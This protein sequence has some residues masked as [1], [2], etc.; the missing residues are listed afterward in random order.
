MASP[1]VAQERFEL[2]G[3]DWQAQP[4]YPADSPEGQLQAIR[5]TL[6]QGRGERAQKLADSWIK[7][8][9][10]HP[11][12]VEAY[13]LRGDAKVQRGRYYESL[14]DYEYLIRN[15]PSSEQFHTA[16]EREFE[17]ARM[18]T[19]GVNRHFLGF[20]ILPAEGEGEELFIRIQE[21]SPGSEIGER[22]SLGLSDYYFDAGQMDLAAEAYDL[23][24]QNY[25]RSTQRE[26]AM[27]RLIQASLAR[28]RGPDFDPTGL[29]E[30][31]QRLRM[32][33]GEF[34]ASADRIGAAALLVRINE[35]LA[36]KDLRSAQWYERRDRDASAAFLYRR[37][38]EQYPE[39]I[40]AQ[41]AIGRLA[42]LDVPGFQITRGAE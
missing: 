42:A 6:A 33:Q 8:Y 36:T 3:G 15:Y 12:L 17:I 25:P 21:R 14:F 41:R 18:F 27:L 26:W 11:L 28:F 22:A 7:R 23:F 35:S 38:I 24:L 37:I 4:S 16:L 39:T 40:A 34:P 31:G 13:L 20:R 5:K 32:F 29:I 2:Q 30:A 9:P 1:A 10:N 19:G